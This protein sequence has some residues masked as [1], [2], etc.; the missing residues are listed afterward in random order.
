[1]YGM[2]TY[3]RCVSYVFI[4]TMNSLY[5]TDKGEPLHGVTAMRCNNILPNYRDN[6]TRPAGPVHRIITILCL[7]KLFLSVVNALFD[8]VSDH[9][10]LSMRMG[11]YRRWPNQ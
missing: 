2:H 3:A 5:C 7:N 10:I 6:S 11:C 1:M 4:V 8:G 9:R